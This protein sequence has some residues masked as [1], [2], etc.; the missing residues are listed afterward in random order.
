MKKILSL[1]LSV[2]MLLSVLP[3]TAGAESADQWDLITFRQDGPVFS[4][5]ADGFI[6][7]DSAYSIK[8]VAYDANDDI[9][10]GE[11]VAATLTSDTLEGAVN[12]E[13]NG[14]ASS[15]IT[16]VVV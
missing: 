11:T 8:V 3:M 1:V 6:A 14:E 7:G 15:D 4:V 2:L 13:K 10:T 16:K 5:K 9:V 12:L